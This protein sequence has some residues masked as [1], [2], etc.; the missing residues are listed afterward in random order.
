MNAVTE[1]LVFLVH[2]LLVVHRKTF[3]CFIET[4]GMFQIRDQS[5]GVVSRKIIYVRGTPTA[6]SNIDPASKLVSK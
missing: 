2:M 3:C 6:A 4:L 5:A 1:Q